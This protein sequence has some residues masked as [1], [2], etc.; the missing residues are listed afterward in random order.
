MRMPCCAPDSASRARTARM[1]FSSMRKRDLD[2]GLHAPRGRDAL[3]D[4]RAEQLVVEHRLRAALEDADL[5]LGLAVLV[6][7]EDA[8]VLGRHDHVLVDQHREELAG[9]R[10]AERQRGHV[11]SG[12]RAARSCARPRSSGSRIDLRGGALRGGD[13]LGRG[14]PWRP[15]AGPRRRR[16][17][18]RRR[19]SR[20]ARSPCSRS[21][22]A[23]SSAPA[24][25]VGRSSSPTLPRSISSVNSG[26]GSRFFLGLLW[27]SAPWGRR[28]CGR[29]SSSGP[30]AGLARGLR[31]RLG[32]DLRGRLGAGSLVGAFVEVLAFVTGGA[33]AGALG[34]A[35][36]EGDRAERADRAAVGAVGE[37]VG[38]RAVA[39][40]RLQE[41]RRAARPGPGRRA[42]WRGSARP[43][44]GSCARPRSRAA[45]PRTR[46]RPPRPP[47]PSACRR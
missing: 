38:H 9:A 29:R 17:R 13:A 42:A 7:G 16:C 47:L 14:A 1:P 30:W 23:R 40:G 27:S 32:R 18:A 10:D 21:A 34:L 46:R 24:R 41:R 19:A 5:D 26:F 43:R 39:L 11:A 12:R 2:L 28:V 20:S 44:S 31:R 35:D 33:S 22:G 15:R 45:R 36:P 37:R 4:E 6:G 3:E 8:L 25:P